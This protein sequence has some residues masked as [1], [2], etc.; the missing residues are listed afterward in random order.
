MTRRTIFFQCRPE[1][2]FPVKA[3]VDYAF[4]VFAAIYDYRVVSR[5]DDAE[6][7]CAYGDHKNGSTAH[8]VLRIPARYR[9]RA[10]LEAAPPLSPVRY[11]NETLYLVHGIDSASGNP[12]W[13]GEI[14]EWLSSSLELP[15]S[16]RDAV[17]RISY[18]DSV[19]SRQKI[20]PLKPY[21]TMLM[22]WLENLLRDGSQSESLPKAIS[23]VSGAEHMVVCSHD[24]DFYFTNCSAALRRLGKNIGISLTHYRSPG[25]FLTNS[26]MIFGLLQGKRPGEYLLPMLDAIEKCGFRSTLFAVANGQ[27]RRD[28]SYRLQNIAP[29]LAEAARRGFSLGLHGSYASVVEEAS[30]PREAAAF[31]QTVGKRPPGSRQHWLRFDSHDKLFRAINQAQL[32]YDSSIGF[33]ES[34][35]FRNGASFAFPPYDFEEERPFSFL[36]IP[37]VVMDGSL[38]AMSQALRQSPQDLAEKI[39]GESRNWGWGGIG[40]LWHNPMEAIQVPEE[41]NRVFWQCAGMRKKYAEQWMSA[42]QFLTAS[43]GRYQSAGLLKEIRF[44]A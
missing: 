2:A 35:G 11:A 5:S 39:L 34:C 28:P 9:V 10:K 7:C 26:R 31:H 33:A 25:Y 4:R 24:V 16:K 14:F 18:S 1:T 17:G 42:D 13:L 22:A 20:S 3:R 30:P 29:Q 23:P 43:L 36:E 38:A 21:A 12:D 40:I 8:K 15:I 41:V 19:F 37:L 6:F 32:A 44:D 27:H